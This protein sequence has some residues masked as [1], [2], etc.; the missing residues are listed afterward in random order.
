M[1]DPAMIPEK[2]GTDKNPRRQWVENTR[3]CVAMFSP[4]LAQQLKKVEG[5]EAKLTQAAIEPA[6]VPERHDA[7]MTRYLPTRSEGIANTMIKTSMER[8]EHHLETWRSMSWEYDPKCFGS[9]LVELSD[10]VSHNKVHAKSLSEVSMA[11]ASL[12][13]TEHRHEERQ[14]IELPFSLN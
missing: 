10:L 8:S 11:I 2:L 12:E 6:A 9:E 5:L 14:G 13:P 4:T 1:T 3:A 7:Q